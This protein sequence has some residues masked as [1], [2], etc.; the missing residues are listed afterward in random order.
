AVFVEQI[1]EERSEAPVPVEDLVFR[2]VPINPKRVAGEPG[3][4]LAEES[5]DPQVR[6]SLRDLLSVLGVRRWE[7]IE[8]K[9]APFMRDDVDRPRAGAESVSPFGTAGAE[10]GVPGLPREPRKPPRIKLDSFSK[11]RDEENQTPPVPPRNSP[12]NNRA[13]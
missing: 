2:S 10:I 1:G 13:Y 7:G 8:K 4:V 3:P 11:E 9:H 12:V 5:P 6:D